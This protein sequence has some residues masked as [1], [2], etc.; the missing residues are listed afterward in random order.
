MPSTL[1]CCALPCWVQGAGY[2]F[3]HNFCFLGHYPLL[4]LKV[5][6]TPPPL[7][8]FNVW[9]ALQPH[10][11]RCSWLSEVLNK[12]SM[13]NSTVRPGGQSP[14]EWAKHM[15]VIRR[16][17]L[18]EDKTLQEVMKIMASEYGFVASYGQ[19]PAQ[20][21][22]CEIDHHRSQDVQETIERPQLPEEYSL[23]TIRRSSISEHVL[24]QTMASSC[25]VIEWPGRCQRSSRGPSTAQDESHLDAGHDESSR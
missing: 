2:A 21:C 12:F 18:D 1:L 17:Y 11:C 10:H 4:F 23:D 14:G 3:C 24:V 22:G 9:Y 15:G 6:T 13:A 19:T 7:T 20:N 25:Q 8:R 16:L 5:A